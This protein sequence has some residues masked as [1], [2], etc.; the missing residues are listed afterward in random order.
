MIREAITRVVYCQDLTQGEAQEV[1]EEI[2]L[3][4]ATPIQIASFITA[5]RMKGETPEEIAGCARSMRANSI[6]VEAPYSD[7]VDTCGT[8]GDGTNTF[9]ISTIVA[10]VGA[11]GGLRVGKHGNR[12]VS[13]RCGSAD[14]LEALGVQIDLG[15]DEVARCIA[16]VGLGFMFAPR[17]HPAMKYAAAPR[18]ETGIRTVFNILG[19]L[20]NPAGA[21]VQLLGVYSRPLTETLAQVLSLLGSSR[22]LVVHGADGLDELSPTGV[23]Y[24]TELRQGEI[25]SYTVAPQS[26]GLPLSRL[27]DLAGGAVEEN[28]AIAERVL[29]GEKGPCRD[30]VL[31]NAAMLFLAA[32]RVA[33]PVTGLKLASEAI[34]SGQARRTLARLV[35]VSRS[36][37][38]KK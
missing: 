20:T 23:N 5:L 35:E 29:G 31:L 14:L 4:D 12:S 13:S 3:G 32:G 30:A 24:V 19:P 7:L 26:L 1:M 38:L 18:R 17:M 27:S 2:M 21:S 16:E 33:D 9:N 36:C 25:I 10:V 11:A 15:P 8:G 6:K 22:A 37:S 28:V 34:D